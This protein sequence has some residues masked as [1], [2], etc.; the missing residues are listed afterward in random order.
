MIYRRACK[1]NCVTKNVRALF[2]P[3][4]DKD[5]ESEF[6]TIGRDNSDVTHRAGHETHRRSFQI[7][8][9]MRRSLPAIFFPPSPRHGPT[10]HVLPCEQALQQPL[11]LSVA[12]E[13]SQS[14]ADIRRELDLSLS[15]S[16][17][18]REIRERELVSSASRR[19]PP[20]YPVSVSETS[21]YRR[22]I[23]AR[24]YSRGS[25]E[26]DRLRRVTREHTILSRDARHFQRRSP[27][28]DFFFSSSNAPTSHD[29]RSRQRREKEEET[30]ERRHAP[31]A[32]EPR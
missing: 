24:M 7:R 29:P 13:S 5:K 25:R 32:K 17:V 16:L 12:P 6:S 31:P 3:R 1:L 22:Y 28:E 18:T 23:P 10:W 19:D 8:S 11:T 2:R 4:Y 14:A 26:A 9:A 15:L 27:R 21:R 30:R 20:S